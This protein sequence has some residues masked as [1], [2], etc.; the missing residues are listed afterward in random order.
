MP[1]TLYFHVFQTGKGEVSHY[2]TKRQYNLLSGSNE[3]GVLPCVD[4]DLMYVFSKR[5]APNVA[6][7]ATLRAYD[8]WVES[9]MPNLAQIRREVKEGVD[10]SIW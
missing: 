7:K 4:H 1:R 5:I 10:R 8:K 6:R 3:L 2:I 9:N